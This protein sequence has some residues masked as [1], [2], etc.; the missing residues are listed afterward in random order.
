M[1]TVNLPSTSSSQLGHVPNKN[2]T[3][4]TLQSHLECLDRLKH[5]MTSVCREM[6]EIHTRIIELQAMCDY[7]HQNIARV[8]HDEPNA[9]LPLLTALNLSGLS[10]P[11]AHG[12]LSGQ[13]YGPLESV[14]GMRSLPEDT[15][16]MTCQRPQGKF[17]LFSARENV[18]HGRQRICSVTPPA[19]SAMISVHNN[20]ECMTRPNCRRCPHDR[21][22]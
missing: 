14:E 2:S 4:T 21:R 22:R 15:D 9:M 16:A 13:E 6:L 5:K 18:D 20:N 11:L 3:K 12:R 8:A 19:V 17:I 1:V 7:E 10:Q